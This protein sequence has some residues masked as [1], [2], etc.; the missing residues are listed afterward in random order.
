MAEL[1]TVDEFFGPAD[2]AM[3]AAAPMDMGAPAAIPSVAPVAE[4]QEIPTVDELFAP[5]TGEIWMGGITEAPS[6]IAGKV[7][8]M[9][10][11]EPLAP[12]PEMDRFFSETFY[13][14]ILDEFGQGAAN[15]WGSGP[16]GN[17][18]PLGL[19]SDTAESLRKNGWLNDYEA[20][21][22]S[23]IKAFNE[24]VIRPSAMA[25]EAG[26]MGVEFAARAFSAWYTG[27]QGLVSQALQETGIER[28]TAR[29]IVSM[30]DAFMGNLGLVGRS[31]RVASNMRLANELGII[32]DGKPVGYAK[33]FEPSAAAETPAWKAATEEAAAVVEPVPSVE[34]PVA[35]AAEAA[36]PDVHTVARN[37]APDVFNKYDALQQRTETFRRWLDELRDNRTKTV[38]E[39]APQ[40]E[41]ID[42]LEARIAEANPRMLKKYEAELEPLRA[43][44]DAYIAE[45]TKGDNSDMA[46]VR[47]ELIKSDIEMRDMAPDV[48]AAYREARDL[49]PAEPAAVVDE[50]AGVARAADE[51][52]VSDDVAAA[53]EP[54]AVPE[55]TIVPETTTTPETTVAPEFAGIPA[56]RPLPSERPLV[57]NIAADVRAKLEGIGRPTAEA[58]AAS[59]IVASHYEARAARLNMTPEELYAV[60]FPELKKGKG[61]ARTPEMA[62]TTKGK[63]TMFDDGRKVIT[64]MEDADASTFMHETGHLWLEELMADSKNTKAV[65]ILK[66]D[67]ETVKKWLGAEGDKITGRQHEK[68]ARGFERY[69]ME[70][71]APSEGLARVFE[72]FRQ[73]L[74]DI[75]KTVA[76][77][78]SPINDEIRGVFDRLVTKEPGRPIIADDRPHQ[79]TFADIHEAD[80]KTTP[81]AD[82]AAVANRIDQEIDEI[83]KATLED[84]DGIFGPKQGTGV[85]PAVGRTGPAEP[86]G[87]VTGA[88]A[89][90]TG[91]GAGHVQ[92][93][94]PDGGPA[95]AG[96]VDPG[97]YRPT[98]TGVG[99]GET[100]RVEIPEPVAPTD[101]MPTPETQFV[102]KAGNIR[103]DN[104]NV[105]EDVAAAIRQ[106]A[107]E[108]NEFVEARRGVMSDAQ[109]LE[110]SEA[111]GMS[112]EVL[113]M[114]KIGEAFNAE[115]IY[116]A[117]KLLV[118]SAEKV[119]EAM[120]KAAA[121]ADA[122]VLAYAEVKAR[123]MMIQEQVAGIT[124]EAG[125]ALRAFR[126]MD[127]MKEAQD[128]GVFLEQ[129]TGRTLNQLR[130][131][132]QLGMELD[133]PQKISKFINDSKR[134]TFSDMIMEFWINALL[135]GPTTHVKNILGNM[136]VAVNRV[137]ETGIAGGIGTARRALGGEGGVRPVEVKATLFGMFQGAKDGIVAGAKAFRT[138]QATGNTTIEARKY[139][140]IPNKKI[141]VG[142]YNLEIGGKQVRIPG[143]ALMA[144]DEFFRAIGGRQELYAIAYREADEAGLVGD[145]FNQ[146][147]ADI[148]SN[149][150]DKQLQAARE[151]ASY[152]TFTRSLG[153]LGRSIQSFANAH[154]L[155][156]VV[157]PF[158]RTPTN[159]LKYAFERTPFGLVS[160]DI[161]ANLS[162]VNG[163]VA[164]DTQLAR[165]TMGTMLGTAF[166]GMALEDTVTGSG[167]SDPREK[168]MLRASG[169]QPYSIKIGD[170]YYSYQWL[171][172]FATIM[173]LS[174]DLVETSGR[175][176]EDIESGTMEIGT[177]AAMMF[178]SI[179]QNIMAKL[180]LR[181]ASQLIEA[182]SNPDQYGERYLQGMAGT[183]VPNVIGQ[184]ARAGDPVQREVRSILDAIKSRIPGQ[185]ETLL[186]RRN[187]WGEPI[188]FGETLGPDYGSPIWTSVASDDPV[189]QAMVSLGMTPS[190]PER[191][192]KNVELTPQQY[193]DYSRISGRYMKTRLD[194]LVAMPQFPTMPDDVKR[195]LITKVITQSRDAARTAIMLQNPSIVESAVE[196]KLRVL[197]GGEPRKGRIKQPEE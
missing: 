168:A 82:A 189:T 115:Q 175:A 63:I 51:A 71:R 4:N 114:R 8:E 13:G 85:A 118:Q 98:E 101:L 130:R 117:R 147:V 103:I 96:T 107:D 159:I 78:R 102:D 171:D 140:S 24:A 170:T 92:G 166:I 15:G 190:R 150:S 93:T 61:K 120:G 86:T 105:D 80:L 52:K 110:L 89:P 179:S 99:A 137:V 48:S 178:G 186:P 144:E 187:I 53:P 7:G 153:P 18:G 172:P 197:R 57:S 62:Q 111:L 160:K 184:A 17:E 132:A 28:R 21:Q 169:W 151:A 183:V 145:S 162:G 100:S 91:G 123:H 156:K 6:R 164:R 141:T 143:R 44:R 12:S 14:R 125:R 124:A 37:I 196:D 148:I 155:A 182:V 74:T 38:T 46:R 68:F 149:P 135:S 19:D 104:L 40:T 60:D 108:G 112:P 158:I 43:E 33:G 188:V 45:N 26:A 122:D 31:A 191:N 116:A 90:G 49:M 69:L 119:S 35:A 79:P 64:M 42:Y 41:R 58:D 36:P 127:G 138:E 157:I 126:A 180:S 133:T 65:Q 34:T 70:G 142:G 121:G 106:A 181:G 55:T 11:A 128:L 50:A 59:Q 165:L 192:I 113:D 23:L 146:R 67:A 32:G 176:I 173:G 81:V 88:P 16:I 87:G 2:A 27:G 66:D 195:K 25:L 83:A 20:G 109:A 163:P 56:E 152:Q 77:L 139:Q 193:D 3:N 75:Y 1:L 97:Q 72:Q 136:S 39:S 194:A 29:D 76:K 5:T 185:R 161:R 129:N 94:G 10:G 22:F 73:W 47:Q 30:P 177:A 174:A 131:E 54:V 84:Y 167:P 134:A 9:F 154:P 95:V